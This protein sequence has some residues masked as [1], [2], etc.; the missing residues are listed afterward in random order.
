MF[1]IKPILQGEQ[2]VILAPAHCLQM[3]EL[4]L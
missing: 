3:E 2:V 4:S 1:L